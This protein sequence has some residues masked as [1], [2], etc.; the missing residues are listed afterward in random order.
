M[1]LKLLIGLAGSA[2]LRFLRLGEDWFYR[3][4]GGLFVCV[5]WVDDWGVL[6]LFTMYRVMITDL[7]LDCTT[8][9]RAKRLLLIIRQEWRRYIF[10]V[11]NWL[12][13]VLINWG[14]HYSWNLLADLFWVCLE[15]AE[16]ELIIVLRRLSEDRLKLLLWCFQIFV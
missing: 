14:L 4:L 3:L 9:V 8:M 7:I 11:A 6:I 15:C 2:L 10:T 1:L 13:G 16:C 5:D 12:Q